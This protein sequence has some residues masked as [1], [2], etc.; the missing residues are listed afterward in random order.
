MFLQVQ[1]HTCMPCMAW[2]ACSCGHLSWTHTV[3]VGKQTPMFDQSSVFTQ[4]ERLST[5]QIK[6]QF[7]CRY[8]EFKH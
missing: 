4:N 8:I 5:L 2:H 1:A 3:A 7:C 6:G